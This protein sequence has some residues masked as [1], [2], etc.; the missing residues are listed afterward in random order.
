M[1]MERFVRHHGTKEAALL[2]GESVFFMMMMMRTFLKTKDNEFHPIVELEALVRMFPY[3]LTAVFFSVPLHA[4]RANSDF[5]QFY[6]KIFKAI[7]NLPRKHRD[8]SGDRKKKL[9]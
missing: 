1:Q 3:N 6:T 8:K 4:T 5:K 7:A 9:F 2:F